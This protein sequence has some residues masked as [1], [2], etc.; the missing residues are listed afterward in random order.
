MYLLNLPEDSPPAI[1][2]SAMRK[3]PHIV[4]F[5]FFCCVEKAVEF[6]LRKA[7]IDDWIWNQY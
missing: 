5:Y 4:D 7:M 3:N 6:L 1:K 2:H